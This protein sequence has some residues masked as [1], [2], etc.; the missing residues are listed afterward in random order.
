MAIRLKQALAD[1]HRFICSIQKLRITLRIVLKN[2][3]VYYEQANHHHRT[4]RPYRYGLPVIEFQDAFGWMSSNHIE[5]HIRLFCKDER[6]DVID[7]VY[8][9]ILVLQ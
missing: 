2:K 7:K 5:L 1:S 9:G 8:D 3:K 6:E 4:A